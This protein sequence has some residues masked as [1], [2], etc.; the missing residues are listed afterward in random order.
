MLNFT[1]DG[2]PTVALAYHVGR[3]GTKSPRT[4]VI[5][6]SNG[7]RLLPIHRRIH[8]IHISHLQLLVFMYQVVPEI[9]VSQNALL[10]KIKKDYQWAGT[11]LLIP[12]GAT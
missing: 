2:V 8:D 3:S 10:S 4:L 11:P 5:E 6:L 1:L 7:K 9:V 12:V